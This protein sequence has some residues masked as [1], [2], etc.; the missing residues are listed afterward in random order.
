MAPDTECPECWRAEASTLQRAM[1]AL[2]DLIDRPTGSAAVIAAF[3]RSMAA[4]LGG[5][6]RTWYDRH[7][8]A[9]IASGDRAELDRMARHVR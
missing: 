6:E 8:A 9:F 7:R 3:G 5:H 1:R 2:G 4:A